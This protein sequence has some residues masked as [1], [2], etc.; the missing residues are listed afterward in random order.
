MDNTGIYT[1]ALFAIVCQSTVKRIA[2]SITFAGERTVGVRFRTT[3][4]GSEFVWIFFA[5]FFAIASGTDERH[6][7][8]YFGFAV[9]IGRTCG[10]W[11][12]TVAIRWTD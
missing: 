7:I 3:I 11:S 5:E 10:S 9:G 4:V 6:T 1:L 8:A 12:D 2:I